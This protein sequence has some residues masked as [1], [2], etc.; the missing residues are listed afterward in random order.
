MMHARRIHAQTVTDELRGL[1]RESIDVLRELLRSPDTPASVRCRAALAII[2]A[3]R[4]EMPEALRH[5][6]SE[7]VEL[8][9]AIESLDEADIDA[10]ATAANFRLDA[11]CATAPAIC[12]SVESAA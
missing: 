5:S 1:G 6:Y 12:P 11:T 3:T 2:D 7:E 9:D 10:A 8:S 4:T